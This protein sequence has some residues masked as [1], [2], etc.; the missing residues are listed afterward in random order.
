MEQRPVVRNKGP[1][2]SRIFIL[3]AAALALLATTLSGG[4]TASVLQGSGLKSNTVQAA[5]QVPISGVI[6]DYYR[7]QGGEEVLGS[8]LGP[9]Q[10]VAEGSYQTFKKGE[11]LTTLFWT[12]QKGIYRLDESGALGKVWREAGAEEG[13][14]FPISNEYSLGVYILQDFSDGTSLARNTLTNE[15]SER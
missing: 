15:V 7:A 13:Y 2:T 10:R 8:P 3:G 1:L 11:S 5:Q 6:A 14:G 12:P 4:S 9:E